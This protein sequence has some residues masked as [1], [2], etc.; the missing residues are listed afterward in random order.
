MDPRTMTRR[1]AAWVGATATA[2]GAVLILVTLVMASSHSFFPGVE[3]IL[4]ELPWLFSLALFVPFGAL[5]AWRRTENAIGW[6]AIAV[7]LAEI[8]QKF[9]TEYAVYSLIYRPGSL[10]GGEEMAW[11]SSWIWAPVLSLFP[12]L[13]LLFPTGSLPGRRWK[14]IAWLAGAT[15]AAWLVV[16]GMLWPL[17]GRAFL[18]VSTFEGLA[19][20]GLMTWLVSL[21]MVILVISMVSLIVRFVRS[22]GIERQQLKWMALAV[23]FAAVDITLEDLVLPIFG[24]EVPNN[25]VVETL[26]G[27]G[28]FIIAATIGIL[29]YRLFDIDLA[30]NRT[31]V[32]GTL[33]ATLALT[34]LAIILVLQ[35]VSSQ[36]SNRPEFVAAST[37]AVAALFR[38]LRA[39]IQKLIDQRFNRRKYDAAQTIESFSERL[40]SEV[41]LDS[42]TLHLLGVVQETMEPVRVSLWLRS[43]SGA[44]GS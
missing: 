19:T 29:R 17:D 10:P 27:P 28:M 7:G 36:A 18:D 13:L 26:A 42:L 16:A 15:T 6:V 2:F 37:L 9:S 31:L 20:Y 32:Y 33:T 34:Y 5:L 40:R 3:N 4:R 11:L 24:I 44:G 39:R 22:H 38:P 35:S 30:I 43:P 21:T 14:W 12:F 1:S 41:D 8:L 25:V 23:G